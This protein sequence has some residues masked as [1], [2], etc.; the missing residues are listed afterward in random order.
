MS[1]RR[2]RLG[3]A[4]LGR[5]FTLMLPSFLA[6]QRVRLAAAA[7]PRPEARAQFAADFAAPAYA[8]VAE[9]CAQPDL[10]A[11]YIATP[12]QFHAEQACL[13]AAAGKHV[14]VEKPMALTLADCARMIDAARAA[15]VHLVIGPSH[16][17]DEPIRRT[18]ALIASGA[19]GSVQMITAFNFTDFLYRPRRPEEL[20][21][22]AGG[23]VFFNQAPHQVDIAR[24]LSGGRV[25]SV[26]SVAGAWDQA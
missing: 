26:R 6:D 23:G 2:L 9:L 8:T 5:A 16:S 25:A 12:H 19:F 13:A 22:K 20:D 24:L 1:E 10:D 17:F 11:V 7:D 4:G 15:G 21:T 3:I 14:L 18:A